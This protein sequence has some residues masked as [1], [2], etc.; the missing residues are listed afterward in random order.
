MM[1]ARQAGRG[2]H[3]H[4]VAVP[5][6]H[7]RMVGHPDTLPRRTG[8]ARPEL[9][10]LAPFI[11]ATGRRSVRLRESWSRAEAKREA[12]TAAPNNIVFMIH[13][14]ELD[15]GKGLAWANAKRSQERTS[16]RLNS[17]Y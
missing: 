13:L 1:Q 17:R 4:P 7:L 16:T 5:I 12:E 8:R 2:A 11:M 10:N 15:V 6:V 14:P 9:R 3:L